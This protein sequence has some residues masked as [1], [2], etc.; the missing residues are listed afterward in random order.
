[1]NDRECHRR[2]QETPQGRQTVGGGGFQCET[3]GAIGRP[4]GIGYHGGTGDGSTRGYVSALPPALA[5]LVP[6]REDMEHDLGGEG[7]EVLDVLYPGE[8]SPS[9]LEFVRLGPQA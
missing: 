5:L 8:K 4:E 2:A 7:G 9:L 3:V 1:M 6:V